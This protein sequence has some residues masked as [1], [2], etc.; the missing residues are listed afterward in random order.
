MTKD[1]ILVIRVHAFLP[2]HEMERERRRIL[3]EK[4]EGVILLTPYEKP[5]IVPAGLVV[6]IQ[7]AEL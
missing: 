2:E 7:E 3:R 4:E 6:R 1:E 5:V